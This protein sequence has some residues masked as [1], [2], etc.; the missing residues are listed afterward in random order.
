MYHAEIQPGGSVLVVSRSGDTEPKIHRFPGGARTLAEAEDGIVVEYTTTH[1]IDGM[2]PRGS[3]APVLIKR[4]WMG[5]TIWWV[6]EH[7]VGQV[8][9]LDGCN[10]TV[11]GIDIAVGGTIFTAY[12]LERGFLAILFAGIGTGNNV[13]MYGYDGRLQWQV[14]IASFARF[15]K[16][17]F[18][19]LEKVLSNG[20]LFLSKGGTASE[21]DVNTGRVIEEVGWKS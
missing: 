20:N 5:G 13:F 8:T 17:P 11:D 2:L 18:S 9:T 14:E 16:I 10:F 1:P 7:H 21:V 12:A 6:F 15:P 19:T 4:E 3:E